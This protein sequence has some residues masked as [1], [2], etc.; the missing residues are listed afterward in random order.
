MHRTLLRRLVPVALAS[1]LVWACGNATPSASPSASPSQASSGAP[2]ASPSGS[3]D[4]ADVY[5]E[6]NAQVRAI[7]GLEEKR[8]I[9]PTILSPDDLAEVLRTSFDEDYPP[10]QVAA[11]EALYHGLGLLPA[12]V[13]L[14]DIY[15]ELLESQVAG[16]YDPIRE[17]LYVVSKEGGVGAVEKVY[18]SHEYDHALQDQQFDL[19]AIQEGLEDQSDRALARQSLVEGDAYVLMSYWLQ[20][21][22]TPEEISEVIA[23]SA[24]PEAQAALERIPQIVQAQILFSALQGTQFVLPMQISGGW[25]AVDAAFASPPET[26]EQILHPAKYASG[27]AAVDVDLP[28]DLAGRMGSGWSVINENT[29]GEHQTAIWLGSPTTAAAAEGAAGW[30]GDRIVVLGGPADAWA[31]AWHTVWDTDADAAE[32]ED[33]AADAVAKAGGPGSVLPGEGGTTRWV[34]IGSD[35]AALQKVAG[36]LGL[37]G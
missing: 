5:A 37:A 11:D 33:T 1:L 13:K 14:A 12:E 10:E 31:I 23:A 15:L 9:E 16:L 2:S 25:P 4:P 19:E 21:H 18:Y 28:D 7:R 27:E 34:V 29:M 3:A 17:R 8:P 22:L 30:G 32:F 26:T 20:Q 36:A 24:D 6:I 35:D